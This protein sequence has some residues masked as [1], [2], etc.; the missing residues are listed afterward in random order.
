MPSVRLK[1]HKDTEI[2]IQTI[3]TALIIYLLFNKKNGL[4]DSMNKQ[5]FQIYHISCSK[6]RIIYNFVLDGI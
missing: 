4:L 1:I 2:I 6:H 3:A 5:V